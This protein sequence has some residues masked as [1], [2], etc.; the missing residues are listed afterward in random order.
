MTWAASKQ[1]PSFSLRALSGFLWSVAEA[2]HYDREFFS[3]AAAAVTGMLLSSEQQSAERQ[4]ADSHRRGGGGDNK[5][6]SYGHHRRPISPHDISCTALAF[7]QFN[8]YDRS[9]K[10]PF[11]PL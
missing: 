10:G 6:M 9:E 11:T 2:R 8:H 3:T 7:A 5:T 4:S 1:L